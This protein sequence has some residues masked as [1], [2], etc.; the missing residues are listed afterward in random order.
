MIVLSEV[1]QTE[2]GKY[3]TLSLICRI[4]KNDTYELI[5]KTETDPQTEKTN[6]W[7]S[8]GEVGEG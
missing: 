6:L 2:K 7:L 3:H 5:F 4:Y 8:K 1:S